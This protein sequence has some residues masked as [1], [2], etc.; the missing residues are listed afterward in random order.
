[1]NTLEKLNQA[2]V[3]SCQPLNHSPMNTVDIVVAMAK[4]AENSGAGAVRIEGVENV[5]AAKQAVAIPVIGIVKRI[6]PDTPVVIT[7]KLCDVTNLVAAGAD[8]IAVDATARSRPVAVETLIA[9]IHAANRLAMADCATL[10]DGKAAL[11]LEC[12][13]IGTTLS[14]YTLETQP[15][16]NEPDFLLLQ[17]FAELTHN[18]NTLTMAE[19]RFNT[20]QLAA[21]ALSHGAD[22]VTVG[23]AITRIENIVGWF[24]DAMRSSVP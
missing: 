16:S 3:V 12:E 9:S 5:A 15:C 1:M 18:A 20:P 23:S 6:E 19:G 17:Q 4:A 7:P 21:S 13:I 14:G 22:C 24:T 8:I 10:G 11:A 2:L